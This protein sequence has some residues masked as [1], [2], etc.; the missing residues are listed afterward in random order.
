MLFKNDERM[1][2]EVLILSIK[3]TMKKNNMVITYFR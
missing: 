2:N 1:E 3:A